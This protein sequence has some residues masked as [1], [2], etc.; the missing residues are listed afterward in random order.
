M[1]DAGQESGIIFIYILRNLISNYNLV[2]NIDNHEDL[3][4]LSHAE[5]TEMSRSKHTVLI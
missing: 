1:N 5:G 2:V 3:Q 4:S